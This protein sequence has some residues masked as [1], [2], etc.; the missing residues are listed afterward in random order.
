MP[1]A[2]WSRGDFNIVPAGSPTHSLSPDRDLAA[3]I[4]S[5][6]SVD[7]DEYA[8]KFQFRWQ[9]DPDTIERHW[10]NGQPWIQI[11]PRAFVLVLVS[12]FIIGSLA[13]NASPF[14][15]SGVAKA[16]AFYLILAFTLACRGHSPVGDTPELM[17]VHVKHSFVDWKPAAGALTATAIM[18]LILQ[19]PVVEA[20]GSFLVPIACVYMVRLLLPVLSKPADSIKENNDSI[21]T[22][23]NTED[24]ESQVSRTNDR[25]VNIEPTLVY[26]SSKI[27]N[28][29]LRVMAMGFSLTILDFIVNDEFTGWPKTCQVSSFTTVILLIYDSG[30][31][32]HRDLEP[33]LLYILTVVSFAIFNHCNFLGMFYLFNDD[34]HDNGDPSLAVEAAIFFA[35]F[36]MM[37]I[38]NRRIVRRQEEHELPMQN[39]RKPVVNSLLINIDP[40]RFGVNCR[41]QL[42]SAQVSIVML[43]AFICGR[44]NDSW[45]L[46]LNTTIA[47]LIVFLLIVGF[48]LRPSR[49]EE[50]ISTV[51]LAALGICVAATAIAVTASQLEVIVSW[52]KWQVVTCTTLVVYHISLTWIPWLRQFSTNPSGSPTMASTDAKSALQD[53]DTGEKGIVSSEVMSLL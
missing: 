14:E 10:L 50:K 3:A 15:T 34:I 18:H 31:P 40:G 25:V 43:L 4:D 46:P 20:F 7:S 26:S 22:N 1:W 29:D 11:S 23:V 30:A 21:D 2:A 51:H 47:S 42:R 52:T 49:I 41:W 9:K 28:L 39:G 35:L 19:N 44:S 36:G 32:A 33:G 24:I 45:P 13:A 38:N 17:F 12:C 8:A 16:A 37:I 53:Y 27:R 5:G 6:S 48:Q